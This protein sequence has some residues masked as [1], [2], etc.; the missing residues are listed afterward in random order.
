MAYFFDFF[1][2]QPGSMKRVAIAVAIGGII[3]LGL[4][5]AGYLWLGMLIAFIGVA[6]FRFWD[7]AQRRRSD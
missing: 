6:S 3:M 2:R 1:R 5:L 4:G 7:Q